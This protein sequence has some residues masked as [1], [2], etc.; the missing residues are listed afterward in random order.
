M[1]VY[2]CVCMFENQSL[3]FDDY[4]GNHGMVTA[5]GISATV[6]SI[7]ERHQIR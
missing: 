4:N 6:R 1:Y 3:K 7:I 5:M 2:T